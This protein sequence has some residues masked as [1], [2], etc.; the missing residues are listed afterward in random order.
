MTRTPANAAVLLAACLACHPVPTRS[1]GADVRAL[2]ADPALVDYV[3]TRNYRLGLPNQT[4]AT[5]DGRTV[6]YLQSGPRSDVRE[7]FAL[8]VASGQTRLLASAASLG[9]SAGGTL[10]AAEA[11]ERERRRLTAKGIGSYLLSSDGNTAIVPVSG[12][13]YAVNVGTGR[14]KALAGKG[15]DDPQLSPD[16]RLLAS[17]VQGE[18]AVQAL[19]SGEPQ[20]LTH[21]ATALVTHGMAEF[22]AEE[23]MDRFEGFWW[24][25]DSA[26]LA[27]EDADASGVEP[28]TLL[29]VAHPEA[30][31]TPTPYPRPGKAN[32]KVRL[33]VVSAG[34][35]TA[36]YVHWDDAAFPYLARVHWPMEG[37]TQSPRNGPL[38][39]EVLSRDQKRLQL[40]RA[41]TETGATT[42]LLEE[43]DAAWVNLTDDFRWL[44]DGSGFLW[45]TERSGYC[46]LELHDPSGALRQ[47]LTSPEL[48]L[49]T[50]VTLEV[51]GGKATG[52]IVEASNDPTEQGLFRL[53]LGDH[54]LRTL[55][56]G[57]RVYSAGASGE[58]HWLI[59][60]ED[61]IDAGPETTLRK[62]SDGARVALI[63]SK[64]ESPPALNVRLETVSTA[65]GTLHA[66]VILPR[67][68][69][70]GPLPVIDWV[71]G[72]PHAVTVQRS[73]QAFELGQWLADQGFAVVKIDNRGTPNRG[74]EF[75][76]VIAGSFAEV[77]LHDQILGL[78]AL[79]AKDPKLDLSRVGSIGASFGGFLAALSVL[80]QPDHF[81]AA[82]AIAPVVDWLDYDTTYTERYLGMP[83]ENA[84]GYRQSS[85]L[86]NAGNLRRPLLLIHGTAD[87]NVHFSG[88][89]QLTHALMLAGIPPTLLA[90]PGAT[91]LFAEQATQRLVWA[92]AAAFLIEHLQR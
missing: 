9:G 16:G 80:R 92:S 85:L 45:T 15:Q 1:A 28:F 69:T 82:V 5:P 54:Q 88:T 39:L 27:F 58:G 43:K 71:Y 62:S 24:S 33:A 21:G 65:V 4:R 6:I 34:G 56:S 74:R 51:Q 19:A 67:R 10:S 72:G 41:D 61:Q 49:R 87:D 31:P 40:L 89:L 76:R 37:T 73:A 79:G 78:E 59:V 11:A 26:Q 44:P 84:E 81:E 46:Q 12:K 2:E 17:V 53:D 29:D 48:G 57:P 60:R 30:Q 25:P 83:N 14:A 68:G 55:A 77:P 91:H 42:L 3:A 38:L 18:L 36:R 47:V 35:G 64:A 8:D 32:V 22:V 75:E 90:V 66:A 70:S 7:L 13:L 50:V 20:A 23:E 63:P 86:T 52:V